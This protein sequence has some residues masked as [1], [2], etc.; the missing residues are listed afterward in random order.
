VPIQGLESNVLYEPPRA[1]DDGVYRPIMSLSVAVIRALLWLIAALGLA[2]ARVH[3]AIHHAILVI[4]SGLTVDRLRADIAPWGAWAAA[5]SILAMIVLTFLPFPADPLILAN[6]AV[7][8]VWKGL[9]VSIAGGL[10]SGCVA[11]GFGRILGRP[12]ALR[13]VPASVV[14]WVNGI[15]AH[16]TWLAILTLQF[17][18][19]IPFS[20]LNFLLGLTTLS[21]ATFLWTLAA[22]ILPADAILVILG[23]GVAEKDSAVYWTLAALALLAAASVPARQWFARKWQPPDLHRPFA[24]PRGSPPLNHGAPRGS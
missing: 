6:G 15:A 9:L 12:V 21:W 10:L 16:G 19:L 20:V 1:P 2:L 7:F 8:G 22:S 4:S 5:I 17:L 14:D 3:P 11:F 18:P 23:R 24:S 13:V